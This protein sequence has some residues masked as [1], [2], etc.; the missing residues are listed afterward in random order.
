MGGGHAQ[1][2]AGIDIKH[3]QPNRNALGMDHLD[4]ADQLGL[5]AAGPHCNQL[6]GAEIHGATVVQM[7]K[8]AMAWC[9]G[10]FGLLLPR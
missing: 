7:L 6:A 5:V 2:I 4:A 1:D 10:R 9:P 3:R 8:V